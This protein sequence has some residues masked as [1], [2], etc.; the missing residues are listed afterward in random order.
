MESNDMMCLLTV[1]Y[2]KMW[3][4]TT[5]YIYSVPYIKHVESNDMIY[6][7]TVPYK[8]CGVKRHYSQCHIKTCGVKRHDISTQCHIKTCGVKR[9]CH[10]KHVESNDMIYLLTVPYKKHVESNDMIYL[11]T[12]PYKTVPYKNMWSQTTWYIYS[13]CHI[14]TCGVKRHDISTH[15]AI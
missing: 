14:K 12:V 10:I 8:T 7:L 2:K 9:Q 13:Q 5:W 11:L 4:Q 6:L 3:S 15:S 1:P